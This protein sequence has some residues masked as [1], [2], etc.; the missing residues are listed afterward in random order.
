MGVEFF[1]TMRRGVQDIRVERGVVAS[2]GDKGPI[3]LEVS[4]S[5]D[6]GYMRPFL[7]TSRREA[8]S[9]AM[10]LMLQ[11]RHLPEDRHL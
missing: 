1:G 7:I 10:A 9:L 2:W 5:P 4:A 11:S 3:A 6:H 8:L